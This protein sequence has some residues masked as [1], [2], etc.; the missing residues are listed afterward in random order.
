VKGSLCA[1]VRRFV[2]DIDY[3][4]ARLRNVCLLSECL[5]LLG[6]G[7]IAAGEIGDYLAQNRFEELRVL[8]VA[9]GYCT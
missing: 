7:R 6:K 3:V 8:L 5:E 4:T 2:L 9:Q 1:V